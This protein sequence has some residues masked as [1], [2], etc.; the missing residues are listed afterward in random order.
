MASCTPSTTAAPNATGQLR[1]QAIASSLSLPH[2]HGNAPNG[3][4]RNPKIGERMNL[5]QNP[6]A[7]LLAACLLAVAAMPTPVSGA[8]AGYSCTATDDDPDLGGT[9]V[10]C[11][12]ELPCN[13]FAELSITA[14]GD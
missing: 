12:E 13:E 6:T 5:K 14:K 3:A 8:E 1:R 10:E 11:E 7:A 4:N 2:R 9:H